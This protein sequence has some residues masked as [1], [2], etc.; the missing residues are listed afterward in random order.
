MTTYFTRCLRKRRI[1]EHSYG[2]GSEDI[3]SSLFKHHKNS[4]HKIDYNK[5]IILDKTSSDNKLL[6]KEMLDINR[7]KPTLKRRRNL[8]YLVSYF[9]ELLKIE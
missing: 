8:H 6:L 9:M 7:L 1:E 3:Q 5:P 4:G 2:I